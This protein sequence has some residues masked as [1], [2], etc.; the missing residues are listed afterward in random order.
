MFV[1]SLGRPGCR[2]YLAKYGGTKDISCTCD[3]VVYLL[4]IRHAC[5]VVHIEHT[6]SAS[7]ARAGLPLATYFLVCASARFQRH[8]LT[9]S[10][11]NYN[12]D[13]VI[14][15]KH[16]QFFSSVVNGTVRLVHARPVITLLFTL[17]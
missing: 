4:Y 5:S 9:F 11:V 12:N 15:V 3:T 16:V 1:W 8:R 7:P 10:Y 6:V 2:V 14:F 17:S 13:A